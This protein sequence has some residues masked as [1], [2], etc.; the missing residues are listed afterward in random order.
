M[1]IIRHLDPIFNLARAGN[2]QL[3]A[4]ADQEYYQAF[5]DEVDELIDTLHATIKI[6]RTPQ[7]IRQRVINFITLPDGRI[8]IPNG[9]DE[10]REFLESGLG[11]KNVLEIEV[12]AAEDYTID[13]GIRCKS[14]IV[15]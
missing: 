3:Y 14:N 9:C 5:R 7:E 10:T 4:L 8:V 6:V 15:V 11:K 12:D 2:G 1:T 13:G